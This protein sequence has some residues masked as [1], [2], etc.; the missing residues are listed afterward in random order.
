VTPAGEMK[1]KGPAN[2]RD[3]ARLAKVSPGTVSKVLNNLPGIAVQTRERVLRASEELDY[4]P[5]RLVRGIF[6]RRSFT[7]GLLTSDSYGRFSGPIM[8]GAEDALG[9]GELSVIMCDSRGDGGRERA[10]LEALLERRIDGLIVT[11]RC[12]NP[13]P[14]VAANL[15]FPVVYAHTPSSDPGD[16]SIT[17]DDANA[18]RLAAQHFV[19]V[20]R[21]KIAHVTGPWDFAAVRKRAQGLTEVLDEHGLSRVGEIRSG[22]WCESWGREAAKALLAENP[23]LDAIF[24]GSDLL[25]RGVADALREAG[26]A[27][28]DDVAIVGTDNWRLVAEATRPPLTTVDLNLATVGR[29][30]AQ[31]LVRAI[32]GE[33]ASGQLAVPASLVVRRSSGVPYAE[34]GI[35]APGRYHESCIHGATAEPDMVPLAG[36]SNPVKQ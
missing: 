36:T 2:I 22:Y 18:G 17:V 3:V 8:A 5:N 12:S 21:R 19:E 13:R 27:V 30:S 1:A 10:H 20:G 23:D 15:P 6:G 35:P 7:V 29:R 26:C 16:L 31:A 9:Q 11:G 34:A 28:P 32:D 25:A 33:A 14:P 24:C 4:R